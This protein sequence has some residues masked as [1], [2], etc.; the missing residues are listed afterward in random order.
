[1]HTGHSTYS[2]IRRQFEY[3]VALTF[4]QMVDGIRAISRFMGSHDGPSHLR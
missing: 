3:E 2:I 4:G 1:M